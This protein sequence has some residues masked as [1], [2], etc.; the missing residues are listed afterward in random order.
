[1][2]IKEEKTQI[3]KNPILEN[4]LKTTRMIVYS[5]LTKTVFRNGTD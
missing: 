5:D 4:A 2:N 3:Y 1:M